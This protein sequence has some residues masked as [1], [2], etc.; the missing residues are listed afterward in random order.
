[1]P[2]E[3]QP[4]RSWVGRAARA[5][6]APV[7]LIA[8]IAL[9][10]HNCDEGDQLGSVE[11]VARAA[12]HG[13]DMWETAAVRPYE[14]PMPLPPA[15]AVPID[16]RNNYAAA[17]AIA[18]RQPPAAAKTAYDHYCRHCHGDNGDN[19]IIVGE[20]LNPPPRDLRSALVQ[21]RGE[22]TLFDSIAYGT[23]YMIPLL[24][25]ID[26]VSLVL[27]LRHVKTLGD[28]PSHPY[29]APKYTRPLQ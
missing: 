22:A 11:R 4:E 9:A 28:A 21:S 17:A 26:P 5:A 8:V 25:S 3:P 12:F 24:E 7:L 15:G 13:W 1:M 23:Q 6:A 20:S 27:A 2:R 10:V 29:Y 19:R 16:G 18:D 14:R